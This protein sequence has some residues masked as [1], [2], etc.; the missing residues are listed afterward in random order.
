[1]RPSSASHASHDTEAQQRIAVLVDGHLRDAG[2]QVSLVEAGAQFV[3]SVTS[4][5][6]VLI[7]VLLVMAVLTALVGSIGLTGT[8]SMNVMERTREIGVLR[9]VGADDGTVA[10]L[11]IVEGQV[12]GLMSYVLAAVASFPITALLSTSSRW[13]C[14]TRRPTGAS[15]PTGSSS[16]S[17]SYWCSPRWQASCQHTA[18]RLTIRG[19]GLRVGAPTQGPPGILRAAHHE[20]MGAVPRCDTAEHYAYLC[21]RSPCCGNQDAP[22]NGGSREPTAEPSPVVVADTRV[23]ADGRMCR[24]AGRLLR[25]APAGAWWPSPW[26]KGSRYPRARSCCAWMMGH[27]AWRSPRRRPRWRRPRAQLAAA[28]CWRHDEVSRTAPRPRWRRPGQ[29]YGRPRVP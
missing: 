5:L 20:R 1:M 29:R 27:S 14:S 22:G 24:G 25:V 19:I 8:V 15:R 21:P 6:D 26:R 28:A 9:T 17:V 7:A 10:T 12:I 3:D 16:G 13:P 4:L 2:F 23:V 18:T 11:V